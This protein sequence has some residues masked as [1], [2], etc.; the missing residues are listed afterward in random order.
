MWPNF[1]TDVT[2][3][4]GVRNWII[5]FAL[6]WSMIWA[7]YGWRTKSWNFCFTKIFFPGFHLHYFFFNLM[8]LFWWPMSWWL[9]SILLK[10][11]LENIFDQMPSY[12]QA[13]SFLQPKNIYIISF[14]TK[15]CKIHVL[16][17]CI[18]IFSSSIHKPP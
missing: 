13:C 17:N 11:T 5:S 10:I 18:Q 8:C 16:L 2:W 14:K 12:F 15:Y 1:P 4:R 7:Y 3:W 9:S 6:I